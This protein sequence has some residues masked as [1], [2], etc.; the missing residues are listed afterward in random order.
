MALQKQNINISL[1]QGLDTKTDPKQ[2]IAGK[3]ITL[4]N[5]I[6]TSPYEIKKRN[7]FDGRSN[8]IQGS[9][10]L[11]SNGAGIA[12]FKNETIINDGSSYYSFVDATQR[13]VNKGA[14]IKTSLTTNTV[15]RNTYQQTN[16]DSA[17]NP[18]G[19]EIFA[20]EDSSGG[21]KC[22]I[23]DQETGQQIKSNYLLSATGSRPRCASIGNYLI[24]FFY[25]T[26]NSRIR[27]IAFPVYNVSSPLAVVNIVNDPHTTNIVYDVTRVGSRI[28]IVYNNNAAGVTL[29]YMDAF[30]SPSAGRTVAGAA[31][32]SISSF[33]DASN[34]VW[35]VYY[36][37]TAVK[38]FIWDYELVAT[39]VLALTTI[40]TLANVVRV[41]G[42]YDSSNTIGEL[43]YE[44]S[45]TANYDHYIKQVTLTVTGTVGTPSVVIRSLGLASEAFYYNGECFVLATYDSTIQPTYFLITK[46][47]KIVSKV[48]HQNGGG[49][50]TR[51]MVSSI[52]NPSTGIYKVSFLQKDFVTAQ[53]G[54][55]FFLLG[56]MNATFDFTNSVIVNSELGNNLHMS[57]GYLSIYDGVNVV[58]HNFHL[59]PEH[60]TLTASNGAGSIANDTYQY[61]AVYEWTDNY[62]QIHRSAPSVPT[63]ITVTGTD[64][65]VTVDVSSLRVTDKASSVSPISVVI[66]R[67]EGS[68]TIF[69]RVSSITSPVY[70]SVT[71]DTVQ[72]VDTYADAA[73]IGN[74][75]LYTTGG[76]VENISAPASDI[77]FN[78]KNRIILVPNENPLQWWFSKQ[79]I[80]GIPVEF[81]DLF[82]KNI[83]QRG[84]SMTGGAQLDDKLIL[85]K[86]SETFFTVGDGPA[87][88]G[89]NDDFQEAQLI[90][91]DVGC[92]NHKSIVSMPLGLMF[93]SLKGIYLL[94]RSL[95]VRYIG[96]DVEDYNSY[97]VNSA[98]LV[99]DKSQV[100]F[101]L[102][103]GDI[104]V[105][106]Y[107]MNQWS[108]FTNLRAVDSA[109]CNGTY[110]LVRST[111]QVLV[112]NSNVYTDDNLFVKLRLR[113]SW[114]SFANLQGFMRVY[115][116]LILGE[117]ISPHKLNVTIAKDFNS[118]PYQQNIIDATT[119]LS[120][121]NYGS[122][123][124]Y[125]ATPYYG[126]A[127]PRYQF[128]LRLQ[129]QKCESVQITVEDVQTSNFG[130]GLSLSAFAFEVGAKY[131]LNKLPATNSFG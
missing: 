105:Y 69:Y 110:S 126:G 34:N 109:I 113:T 42:V 104:L 130:E 50:P 53:S 107:Y 129:Q 73:I 24:V 112:E 75:Q 116:L 40:E 52:I 31:S 123:L 120:T 61:V 10:S 122:D 54:T 114:L 80:P 5:A 45:Q 43:F 93:K 32:V 37:G 131:G 9:T 85:F 13:W 78:Y 84:G 70:N 6:F 97:N 77:F 25:D 46:T 83:D 118:N 127:F 86:S 39:P 124:Y 15:V 18:I 28:F 22:T 62:G 88:S 29:K 117:Y 8:E 20:W 65:T 125:G 36:N 108:V 1:A 51:G 16:Q 92:V 4:E 44:V 56:V 63:Q 89:A 111:G 12:G 38:S 103:S 96:A 94:D 27:Y 66:Y 3:L 74:E 23:V 91:S 87:P 47:G 79:V 17:Y 57:G 2:V 30:L 76:E 67:T 55:V 95:G 98:L 14:S 26:S 59:F 99:E 19:M 100:R 102:D 72:F 41:T 119:L 81:S 68:G 90:T 60:L 106:D 58:E 33:G 115:R 101:A 11:V 35:V 64:D 49:L 128:R 82:V 7:G 21:V 121:N 71:A 48:S